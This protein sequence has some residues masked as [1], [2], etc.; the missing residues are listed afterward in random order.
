MLLTN[1]IV[2]VAL[3][4]GS[5]TSQRLDKKPLQPNLDNLEAGLLANTHP[6]KS[7]MKQWPVGWIP[8]NCKAIVERE[9]MNP[10]DIRTYNVTYDDCKDSWYLCYHKDSPSPVTK[11]VEMMG[12]IPVGTRQWVRHLVTLPSKGAHAYNLGGDVAMFGT[13]ISGLTVYFHE[14]GHSLDLHGAY[15]NKEVLSS[16]TKWINSYN[17]DSAVPDPYAQTNQIEN[18]AQNTVVDAYARIAPGGFVALNKGASAIAHQ[19]ATLDAEQKEAG[20]LL[21]PGGKCTQRLEHSPAVFIG[22]TKPKVRMVDAVHQDDDKSFGAPE[23]QSV[24]EADMVGETLH[25]PLSE[26]VEKI[27]H[28]HFDTKDS[29]M[30]SFYGGAKVEHEEL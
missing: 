5:V 29:C 11:A 8:A 28:V 15:K 12:R 24:L 23:S 4:L 9:N 14:F 21:V 20:N 26:G 27:P 25:V 2:A 22:K 13:C 17:L 30:D 6:A 18:V 10:A 19:S 1:T 3:C 7:T 16:S